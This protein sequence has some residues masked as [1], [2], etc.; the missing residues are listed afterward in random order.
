MF[1]L[2]KMCYCNSQTSKKNSPLQL[3]E[4][5]LV[6]GASKT[7]F[8][9]KNTALLSADLF[10]LLGQPNQGVL[11]SIEHILTTN[12]YLSQHLISEKL[13]NLPISPTKTAK[14]PRKFSKN[15]EISQAVGR[16]YS[17]ELPSTKLRYFCC[18]MFV[19]SGQLVR[20]GVLQY[21]IQFSNDCPSNIWRSGLI[22]EWL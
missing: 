10:S 5:T 18:K 7:F 11:Y 14:C 8:I 6:T 17:S 2:Q 13:I 1:F 4:S 3:M 21:D 15:Q 12:P 16:I 19:V 22:S 20:G 9:N